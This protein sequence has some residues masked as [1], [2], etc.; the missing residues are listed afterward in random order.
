MLNR[1]PRTHP[2]ESCAGRRPLR[3]R[4]QWR[5]QPWPLLLPW[6]RQHPLQVFNQHLQLRKL[7]QH[8]RRPL[9]MPAWPRARTSP[10][11]ISSHAS[12]AAT[13]A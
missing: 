10:K 2:A 12:C 9:W 13:I 6:L 5:L 8:P 4:P 1:L 3:S 7:R 11:P